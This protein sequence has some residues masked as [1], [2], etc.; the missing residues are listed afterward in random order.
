MVAPL[1]GRRIPAGPVGSCET[2]GMARLFVAIWPPPE[3]V[4]LLSALDRPAVPG[5]RWSTPEQWMVKVRPLGHVGDRVVPPLLD[6]LRGELDG[7]PPVGCRLGPSTRR[8][9]GQWLGVPVQGL[10]GLAAVVFQATAGLVPVTHPQPFQADVV[11]ARGR[12]P[13]ALAGAPVSGAWTARAVSLVADRSS[14][15]AP[16]YQ[17]L[18]VIPLDG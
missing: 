3:V 6:L 15:W 1:D 12:V 10:D 18:A 8:L 16:R 14:P 4:G 17:D 2:G 11:L 13:R 9:G 7:A 5:V